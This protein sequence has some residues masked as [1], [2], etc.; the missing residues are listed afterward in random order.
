[1][2]LNYNC[3]EAKIYELGYTHALL[4]MDLALYDISKIYID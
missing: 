1:M 3:I 2:R 4:Q